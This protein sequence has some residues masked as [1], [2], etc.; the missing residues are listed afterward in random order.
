MERAARMFRA[1]GDAPRLRLLALLA[2][3]DACVSEMAEAEGEELS[4]ISQRLRV[5][6]T[7]GLVRCSRAGKQIFYTLADE[8]VAVLVRNA[9]AHAA[10]GHFTGR[11][12]GSSHSTGGNR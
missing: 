12:A 3:R 10:E 2:T 1:L 9:M 11:L 5:L 8:H 6:R 4:T 7:E